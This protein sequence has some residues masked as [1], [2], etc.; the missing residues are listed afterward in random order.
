MSKLTELN[1]DLKNYQTAIR[2]NNFSIS[3]DIERKYYLYGLPPH[4]VVKGLQDEIT[5]TELLNHQD[6]HYFESIEL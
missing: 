1:E 5:E 2:L 6:K 4:L 3:E